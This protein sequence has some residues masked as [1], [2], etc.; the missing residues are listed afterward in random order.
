MRIGLVVVVVVVKTVLHS[1]LDLPQQ[2]YCA[3]ED[4]PL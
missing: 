4:P 1:D 3:I 2:R